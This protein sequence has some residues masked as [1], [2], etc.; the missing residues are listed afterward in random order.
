MNI[1]VLKDI[2]QE[3]TELKVRNEQRVSEAIEKLGENYLLH[4]SNK[5]YKKTN[6]KEPVL[7]PRGLLTW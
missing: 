4:P 6:L 2:E 3:L 1:D 7:K 5:V